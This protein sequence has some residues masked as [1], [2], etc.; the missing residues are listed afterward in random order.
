MIPVLVDIGFGDHVYPLPKRGSFPSLLQGLPQ[1][2]HPDAT[3]PKP[4]SLRSWQ[5]IVHRFWR[6][7][8]PDQGLL[9]TSGS[10]RE[11]F[12]R[13]AQRTGGSSR[14]HARRRGGRA[15]PTRRACGVDRG[16]RRR[17]RR[18]AGCGPASSGVPPPSLKPPSFPQLQEELRRFSAPSSQASRCRKGPRAEWRPELRRMAVGHAAVHLQRRE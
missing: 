7:Q 9:T 8:R 18:G 2:E 1:V 4:S 10:R 17:R 14:R 3:P 15:F 6:G 12:P 11:F 13:P 16:L 5:A